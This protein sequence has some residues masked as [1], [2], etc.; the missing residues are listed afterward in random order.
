MVQ[1][2][3]YFNYVEYTREEKQKGEFG[4]LSGISTIC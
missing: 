3:E 1:N 2:T 4:D